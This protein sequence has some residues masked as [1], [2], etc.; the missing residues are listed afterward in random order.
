MDCY[1]EYHKIK[2]QIAILKDV[3]EEYPTA[4]L[5]NVIQQLEARL[6]TIVENL[7]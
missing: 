7:D 5:P 1:Y 4:S 6:A 3:V 2:S